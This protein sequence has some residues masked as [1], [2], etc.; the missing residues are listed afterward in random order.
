MTTLYFPTEDNDD[1]DLK[2]IPHLCN[3]KS[4]V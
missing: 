2:G 4:H 3:T 1:D